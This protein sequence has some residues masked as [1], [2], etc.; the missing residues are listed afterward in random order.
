MTGPWSLFSYSADVHLALANRVLR[1]GA[2]GS[3]LYYGRLAHLL[4]RADPQPLLTLGRAYGQANQV[5]EAAGV[6]SRTLALEPTL[7]D[8]YLDLGALYEERG[9]VS[10]ARCSL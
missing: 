2:G 9:K 10:E 5:D 8:A 6:Y 4:A 1:T 3:A 7:V